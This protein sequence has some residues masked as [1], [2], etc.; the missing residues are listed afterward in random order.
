M[1]LIKS[2]KAKTDIERLVSL[3][4]L[5][6][7]A[8]LR[9]KEIEL[10]EIGVIR[11]RELTVAQRL[12]WLEY[13]EVGEDG[14]AHWSLAKQARGN[15]F[16]ISMG[17]ICGDVNRNGEQGDAM[18]KSVNDVPELRFDVLDSLAYEIMF[19]SGIVPARVGEATKNSKN[20]T[21]PT[22]SD[23]ASTEETPISATPSP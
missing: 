2:G 22:T 5:K 20:L 17:V 8:G 9:E 1:S 15:Q 11:I 3:E 7:H 13:M 19:L 4:K 6:A 16:I 21:S 23:P 12:A 14:K 18:F 10:P